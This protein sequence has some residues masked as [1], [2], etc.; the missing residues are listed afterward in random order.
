M[1]AHAVRA[2]VALSAASHQPWRRPRRQTVSPRRSRRIAGRRPSARESLGDMFRTKRPERLE[3]RSGRTPGGFVHPETVRIVDARRRASNRVNFNSTA[4]PPTSKLRRRRPDL[5][6]GRSDR[7]LSRSAGLN[8]IKMVEF[9][10]AEVNELF[11]LTFSPPETENSPHGAAGGDCCCA[12]PWV[13]IS[14]RR[15]LF[16]HG[17]VDVRSG[18]VSPANR[19]GEAFPTAHARFGRIDQ[20]DFI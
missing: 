5:E 7:P 20:R 6:R 3:I 16:C 11:F 18:I 9:L 17:H 8:H 19:R 4:S 1:T 10:C 12:R 14:L 2:D 15:P 13:N